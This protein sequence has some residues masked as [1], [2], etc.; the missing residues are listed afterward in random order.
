MFLM[1]FRFESTN[2]SLQYG[3]PEEED[4]WILI[5]LI[6]VSVAL[7]HSTQPVGFEDVGIVVNKLM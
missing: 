3:D 6:G 2:G 1:Y 4:P 7:R 5:L